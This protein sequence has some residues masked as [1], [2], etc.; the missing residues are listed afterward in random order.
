MWDSSDKHLDDRFFY[1]CFITTT[2]IGFELN[3]L[4][5]SIEESIELTHEHTHLTSNCFESKVHLV[6]QASCNLFKINE[7][8]KL[9]ENWVVSRFG[10]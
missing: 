10:D 1:I 3:V 6:R 8:A 7:I 9:I 2:Y 5:E 4:E